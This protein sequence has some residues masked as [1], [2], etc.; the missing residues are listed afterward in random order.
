MF[1]PRKSVEFG[2]DETA[3]SSHTL[4]DKSSTRKT[5]DRSLRCPAAAAGLS[6]GSSTGISGPSES[7]S[8]LLH[9]LNIPFKDTR[10]Q[11]GPPQST[12]SRA[13]TT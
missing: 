7:R 6:G 5:P 11:V 4:Y 1:V 10:L 2:A 9:Y 3:T 12:T 8:M 13:G